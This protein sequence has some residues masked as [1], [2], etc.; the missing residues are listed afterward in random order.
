MADQL[1]RLRATIEAIQKSDEKLARELRGVRQR[2]ESESRARAPEGALEAAAPG[3]VGGGMPPALETIV[4]RTGRPV[5]AVVRDEARLDFR[6][7]ESEQWRSRLTEARASIVQ[8]V[9]AVGR[10]EL[11]GHPDYEWVG[12][13]WLVSDD[14]VVTNRHV[15]QVFGE[16]DGER[17]VFRSGLGSEP[18][19]ASIDFIEEIERDEA[20]EFELVEILHIEDENGPDTAFLRVAKVSGRTL[21]SPIAL[22]DDLPDPGRFVA[23][24]GYPARDSRIPDQGLMDQI[25]GDVYNKKRLAPGQVRPS[26]DGLVLHD[27]STLGGNSGSVVLDLASGKAVALHFSGRFLVSNYAVPATRLAD[28]LKSLNGRSARVKRTPATTTDDDGAAHGSSGAGVPAVVRVSSFSSG[29]V[30]TIPLRISVEVGAPASRLSL[31]GAA[32]RPTGAGEDDDFA[33]SEATPADYSNR[34]GYDEDFLGKRMRVPLPAVTRRPG[35]V[36]EF[37]VSGRKQQVLNYEH[38]SVVMNRPRRMCYFS[39]VNIDGK[40][41]RKMARRAWRFDPRVAQ[42]LQIKGECYGDPPR[43][44][45]GHMTRREDPIW[46]TKAQAKRGG[47]DSMHVTNAVPQMQ[48]FNAPVWLGLEDYALEHARED[49]MRISVIT[50]PFL[51][52]ND[53][54]RFEVKVPRSFWKVIAFVHDRTGKLCATGYTM[55]QDDF[56]P[57]EEFVFGQYTT[58]QH[59]T[60]QTSIRAIEE[61]AGLSFG[62]LADHDPLGQIEGIVDRP[63]SDFG[64][65]RFV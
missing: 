53:P 22:A 36:L 14:V 3:T 10:I 47:D 17:Y 48:P 58:P 28:R 42:E 60:T 44:S 7:A 2:L 4:L 5:L 20:L 24:I 43:F 65:I 16:R 61:K 13:G 33:F 52:A 25:F 11:R 49:D 37:E 9:R 55:S 26:E 34:K 46:G 62:K 32:G 51:L 15:A 38:F 27:C 64:Q 35:D 21:A 56:L 59:K 50:G 41:S 23:V 63:L 39:A 12:T 6:D 8:A 18:V 57:E 30:C 29:V 54:V 45:R 1:K 40:N 19:E 31:A